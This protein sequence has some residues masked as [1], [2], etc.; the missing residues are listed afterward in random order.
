MRCANGSIRVLN[1]TGLHARPAVKLTQTA[2]R[3]AAR[4]EIATSPDGPWTDAKSPVRILRV[5]A[6]CGAMLHLR[7]EGQDAE[8]ALAAILGLIERNFDETGH[9]TGS[10]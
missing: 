1:P 6:A 7:T 9:E 2:K 3:F 10:E 5:K 8:Q 4:I